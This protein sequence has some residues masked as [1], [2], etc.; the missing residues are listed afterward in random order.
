MKHGTIKI[1]DQVWTIVLANRDRGF[2]DDELEGITTYD[3]STIYLARKLGVRQR[4]SVLLHE[5]LHVIQPELSEQ[6]VR[7]LERQL[8]PI[9]WKGGWRPF[10]KK[11]PT[12]QTD[13]G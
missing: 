6:A 2:H 8:F 1:G 13:D 3:T 10:Q 11:K 9:L 5:I 7:K 4:S 12:P